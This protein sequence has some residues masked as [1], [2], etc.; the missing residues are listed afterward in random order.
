MALSNHTPANILSAMEAQRWQA[1][2]AGREQPQLD[3]VSVYYAMKAKMDAGLVDE[4]RA[5]VAAYRAE[6][7][8]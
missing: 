7:A 2:Q 4:A 5:I 1:S 8:V 6:R 3:V